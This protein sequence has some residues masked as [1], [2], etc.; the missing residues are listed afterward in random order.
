MSMRFG[1]IIAIAALA[2]I[3]LPALSQIPGPSGGGSGSNASVGS[4]GTTAPTS[5]TSIGSVNSGGNLEPVSATN[6]LPVSASVTASIAGFAPA[7]VYATIT[8]GATSSQVALPAGTVVVVYNTGTS[9]ASVKLGTNSAVTA[10]VSNDQVAAGGWIAF[11]VGSNT[12]L[13]AI[14]GT[15]ATGSTTLVLSGGSGIPTGTGGGAGGG[16]SSNASVSATGTGV[17]ASATYAAMN[18]SGNLTGLVGTANGLKVDGS[19]VTQPISAAALPLPT[20]AAT[21]ANQVPPGTAGSPNANVESVQGVAGGTALPISGTV[22]ISGTATIAGTVTANQGTPNASAN[23]WPVAPTIAGA[24]NSQTNGLFTNILQ[25]NAVNS[26]GN[27]IFVQNTAGTALLGKVGIDQTTPGTTNA[28]TSF[29][30]V[31][32][33][34][35]A[36][37]FGYLRVATP[38]HQLFYDGFESG[39]LDTTFNWLAAISGGGGVAFSAVPGTGQIGSGTTANGFSDIVTR[40]SFAPVGPSFLLHQYS[41]KVPASI[42]LNTEAAW[43]FFTPTATPTA[44]S[45][46][47]EGCAFEIQSAASGAEKMFTVCFAGSV[48]TSITDLSAATGNGKQPTDGATH[49]Y[50]I[51]FSGNFFWF[52][53]DSI[54]NVVST[55]TSGVNG[56]NLNTQPLAI[57]TTAGTTAPLSSLTVQIGSVTLGDEGGNGVNLHD[58]THPYFGQAV[59]KAGQAAVQTAPYAATPLGFGQLSA[60]STATALPTIP[61]GAVC[62]VVAVETNSIRFRDDGTAPTATVGQLV[63]VGQPLSI[64]EINAN[65]GLTAVQFIPTTGSATIDVSYYR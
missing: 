49:S 20:G 4:N 14:E 25:G 37:P 5:S 47:T 1:R 3:C 62:A 22:G 19:A 36:E 45:P 52:A 65:P 9:A 60:I 58:A 56:P 61:A 39:T 7:S 32:L 46:I 53:I 15:G 17:P 44:A 26:T 57:I 23:A 63:A 34:T 10:T 2:L 33:A 40:P 48:R 50:Y 54:E 12:N 64:C 18:V 28:I 6:P 31:G 55:Q 29:D 59:N 21:A 13:A 11:T 42:P 43:G 8:A 24:A 41:I 38:A 27:P 16:S 30:S 51:W 35:S